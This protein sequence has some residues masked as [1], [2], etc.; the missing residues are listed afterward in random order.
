MEYRHTSVMFRP[1]ARLQ[2]RVGSRS[3]SAT[4]LREKQRLVILGSGWG[5]Y[6]VLRGVDKK[7]WGESFFLA[8]K[9][10]FNKLS[11]LGRRCG[12]GITKQLL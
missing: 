1:I 12:V 8:V 2:H 7:R 9:L 4:P 3:F 10:Q 6:E 5:G 11:N